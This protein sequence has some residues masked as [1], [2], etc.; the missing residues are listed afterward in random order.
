MNIFSLPSKLIHRTQ[1]WVLTTRENRSITRKAVQ[2]LADIPQAENSAPVIFF[3]AST[4]TTDFTYNSGFQILVSWA[5]RLQKVPVIHFACQSGMSHCVLG[6]ARLKPTNPPPCKA[7]IAHSRALH[8][9]ADVRW[10]QYRRDPELAARLE[11]LTITDLLEFEYKHT[12]PGLPSPAP[13]GKLVAPGLRWILRRHNLLDNDGTRYLC[14]EF[15]LSAWNIAR[16]F[17]TLL[18]QTHPRA[19]VVFNGQ[20]FPEATA[21]W[22][23]CNR[24]IPSYAHEVGLLP[25]SAFFTAGEPT[26]YPI[27]IPADFELNEAQNARLDSYLEK[28]FQGNFT[29]AGIKFW[30]EMKG[31]DESLI[32]KIDQFKQV[33]PVFTNVI[34]DTSQPHANMVFTDMFAWLDEVLEIARRHSETL[35]VIRA[36]PDETRPGKESLETV[37]GWVAA[38]AA[39]SLPNLLFIPPDERLSSYELIQRSKFVMIYNSTIGLEAAI[40]GAS[41]LS[42]GQARFTRYPIVFFPNSVDEF[43]RQA[44]EFLSSHKISIPAEFKRNARKFLYYQL[45]RT[46]LPFDRYLTTSYHPSFTHFKDFPVTALLPEH[47]PAMQTILDGIL[48]NGDFL[49]RE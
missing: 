10:F 43:R 49:L 19:V 23:A 18:D 2:V 26:A 32:G 25:F 35:F 17:S 29:M 11:S 14:R 34:F 20:F 36:H 1:R 22:L 37:S 45:F 44:E 3:R 46:S 30:P 28:R 40:M 4:G 33:V 42:G 12:V 7:C 27:D 13:L 47:S 38:R 24:G 6:T 21:R 16:E 39:A 9:G 41:V 48:R 15:M 31:L 5:L 8:T